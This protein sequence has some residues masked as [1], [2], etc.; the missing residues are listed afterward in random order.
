MFEKA[1]KYFLSATSTK[2]NVI[3]AVILLMGVMTFWSCSNVNDGEMPHAIYYWRTTLTLN[4]TERAAIDSL[5]IG[6]IYLHLF[7][8]VRDGSGLHPSAT[9]Q[10]RDS[11]REG[12]EVVP[13]VFIDEAALRSAEGTDSLGSMIVHRVDRMLA[14]NG[15]PEAQELQLD[16]DWTE[17]TR[18]TFYRILRQAGDIMHARGGRISSTIRLHQLGEAPPPADCGVLMLYNTGDFRSPDEDNSILSQQSVAPYLKHLADYPLPLSTALPIYSWNLVYRNGHFSMIAPALP[19]G[20]SSLFQPIDSCR[21]VCREYTG[22]SAGKERRLYP[23]DIVRHE[24]AAPAL[25]NTI[26]NEVALRRPSAGANLVLYH[27][28]ANS[29]N[30]YEISE[31]QNLYNRN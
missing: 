9:L 2:K 6:R 31:L 21:F 1:L 7:D 19:L 25:L 17:S 24:F 28:D 22:V 3:S 20:E 10:F 18:D 13:V 4:D 29:L 23:G 8:V 30:N 12:I 15:Y 14:V 16:Y 5:Q 11:I 27:L 26:L